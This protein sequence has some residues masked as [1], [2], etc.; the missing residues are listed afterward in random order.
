MMLTGKL[1]CWKHGIIP[2]YLHIVLMH[3]I[4][5]CR[6]H[7]N[8][9]QS[10]TQPSNE[11]THGLRSLGGHMSVIPFADGLQI[12]S[13]ISDNYEK[14]IDFWTH[15]SNFRLDLL[16]EELHFDPA[17][18]RWYVHIGPPSGRVFPYS[19]IARF[20]IP[21][22]KVENLHNLTPMRM[23][24]TLN[25]IKKRRLERFYKLSE[26]VQNNSNTKVCWDHNVEN[27]HFD[28][29]I[30]LLIWLMPYGY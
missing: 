24:Q 30:N 4:S 28:I 10:D 5:H 15:R 23:D 8:L 12:K 25:A 16:K 26:K 22:A 19:R 1:S 20:K 17:E 18:G 13:F 2:P 21:S 14:I 9:P 29:C 7:T 11:R 3:I 27:I 6:G